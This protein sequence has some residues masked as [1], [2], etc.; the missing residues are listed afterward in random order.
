MP[1]ENFP[2]GDL[3]PEGP[4]ANGFEA[5]LESLENLLLTEAGKLFAETFQITEGVVVNKAD[6]AIKFQQGVLQRS[7]G[8][9]QLRHFSQRQFQGVGN[10]VA[11][12]V[13]VPEA[14][15]FVDDDDIP[16]YVRYVGSFTP[17]EP[18]M[19]NGREPGVKARTD[20]CDEMSW[21]ARFDSLPI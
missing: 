18:E 19:Q 11:G 7:G 17:R 9:K 21:R 3:P 13:D 20:L 15:G 16:G 2:R 14:V 1:G 12:F 8:E 6:Q 10:D 5:C 4:V